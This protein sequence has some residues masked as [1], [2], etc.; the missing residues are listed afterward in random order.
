MGDVLGSLGRFPALTEIRFKTMGYSPGFL[1][2]IDRF[3]TLGNSPEISWNNSANTL[4]AICRH[5]GG[6]SG[7]L[8][9][10]PALTKI[11][12]KTMGYSPGLLV[13]IA[14]FRTLGNSPE[15]F[16]NNPAST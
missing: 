6:I 10:F 11:R 3:R 7:S 13:K 12:Y 14:R 15:I 5:A 4:K 9:R 2:K 8:G 1:V 16:S